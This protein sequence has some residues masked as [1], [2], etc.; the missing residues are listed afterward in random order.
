LNSRPAAAT[1]RALLAL[2][3]TAAVVC[4]AGLPAGEAAPATDYLSVQNAHG[5]NSVV[6]ML[7][8]AVPTPKNIVA[9]TSMPYK[10]VVTVS[11]TAI[12]EMTLV[13]GDDC[14]LQAAPLPTGTPPNGQ[15][16]TRVPPGALLLL[17]QGV[18]DCTI[19]KPPQD[20]IIC[21]GGGISDNSAPSQFNATCVPGRLFA[22]AVLHGQLE[23]STPDGKHSNLLA[24][25]ALSCE[26]AHCVPVIRPASFTVLQRQILAVQAR[27][28][29]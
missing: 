25:R 26:V 28:V 9:L 12:G 11:G 24:G 14:A 7:S 27:Q 16:V 17:N 4:T 13:G 8:G 2:V 18:A 21:D 6:T 22:V 19:G 5:A 3:L 15:V 20:L 1:R 29:G 23:V 10:S